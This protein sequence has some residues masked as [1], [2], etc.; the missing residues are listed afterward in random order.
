MG[1]G[2]GEEGSI[3]FLPISQLLF[4]PPKSKLKKRDET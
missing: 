1:K 2:R 4:L 3:I